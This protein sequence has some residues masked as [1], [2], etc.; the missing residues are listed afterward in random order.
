MA[1]NKWTLCGGGGRCNRQSAAESKETTK[2][3]NKPVLQSLDKKLYANY[4]KKEV[5]L[6]GNK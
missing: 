3:R 5:N 2:V 4:S 6:V 1:A